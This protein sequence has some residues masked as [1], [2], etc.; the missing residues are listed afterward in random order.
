LLDLDGCG[1][2]KVPYYMEKS[3]VSDNNV[4]FIIKK[5]TDNSEIPE[6]AK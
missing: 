2:K 5:Q 1:Y 3:A 4:D 6:Q